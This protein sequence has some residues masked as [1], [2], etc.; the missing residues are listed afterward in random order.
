MP[1]E[2]SQRKRPELSI[3]VHTDP[4]EAV[5]TTC[6]NPQSSFDPGSAFGCPC[7]GTGDPCQSCSSS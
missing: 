1:E 7:A 6:K 5:L 2:R 3:L 4:R